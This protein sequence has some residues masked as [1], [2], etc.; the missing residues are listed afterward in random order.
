[1][2][3]FVF[4]L[5][6]ILGFGFFK[7]FAGTYPGDKPE[8]SI[9]IPIGPYFVHVHHWLISMVILVVLHVFDASLPLLDGLL[10]G[11]MLQGLT[12]SDWYRIIYKRG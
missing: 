6:A 3:L 9:R 11:S 10:I 8:R 7:L 12:Y 5:G 2:D 1:M 4:V